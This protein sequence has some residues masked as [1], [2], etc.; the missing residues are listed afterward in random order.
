MHTLKTLWRLAA[1][2]LCITVPQV[3]AKS[4]VKMPYKSITVQKEDGKAVF[5]N[6]TLYG[7]PGRPNLPVYTVTFLLPAQ[8]DLKKISVV[9][10]NT[11]EI[12]LDG[13]YEVD[14]AP[15]PTAAGKQA[16][17]AG[18]NIVNGKDID[19]YQRNAFYPASYIGNISPGKMRQYKLVNV[20]VNPVLYNPVTKKLKMITGGELTIYDSPEPTSKSM[21]PATGGIQPFSKKIQSLAVNFSDAAASYGLPNLPQRM[22]PA[23]APLTGEVYA[24]ITTSSIASQSNQLQNFIN[25]KTTRGFDVQLFDET[26]WGGGSGDAAAENI[27]TWLQ[28]NYFTRNIT[29]V[30]LIGNPHPETGD[31]PMKMA[32]PRS[33]YDSHR[34]C[35]TDFYFAELTGDWDADGDLLVGEFIDDF[36]AGDPDVFAEVSVG[37]IPF[38][39]NIGDLDHILAKIITYENEGSATFQWRAN[40]LIPSE[41]LDNNTPGYHFAEAINNDILYP[42]GWGKFRIYEKNY[43]VNPELTPCSEATTFLT[44]KNG[45]YGAVNWSTHGWERGASDIMSSLAALNLN[46]Q[47]PSIVFQGSCLNAYPEDDQNLSYSL[48]KNGAIAALGA[49]RVSWYY[50]GET[51][52][53]NSSSDFGFSYNFA[54]NIV[55][56]GMFVG[57]ALMDLRARV[58]VGIWMNFLV[59]NVY[60]D[61]AVG[62]YTSPDNFFLVSEIPAQKIFA[63][64]SFKAI[65][66]N[67]HVFNSQ[68]TDDQMTWTVSGNINLNVVISS[69]NVAEITTGSQSWSGKEQITFTATT[70]DGEQK[71]IVA[72]FEIAGSQMIYLSDM[73]WV[74]AT[75]SWGTI[76]K[77]LSIDGNTIT[78][79][80]VVYDKGIGTHA[81]SE[82]VYQL[83]RAYDLFVCTFGIDDEAYGSADFQVYGDDDLL[84]TSRVLHHGESG[85]CELW[86]KDYN[87]LRLVVGDGGDGIGSDHADW[88]DAKLVSGI[89]SP[90]QTINVSV[91]PHVIEGCTEPAWDPVKIYNTDSICSHN[92]HI[93]RAK[94]WTQG[95]EPGTTG[96]WGVWEVLGECSQQQTFY[97]GRVHPSGAVRV[98]YNDS[99][100]VSMFPDSG[101]MVSNLSIDGQ[102]V[103]HWDGY[104]TFR[105]VTTDHTLQATFDREVYY[106][107]GISAEGTSEGGYAIGSGNYYVN[108]PVPIVALPIPGYRFTGWRVVYG[109]CTVA[110]PQDP[111]TTITSSDYCRV[112]ASYEV[113]DSNAD[114]T[115][116][117]QGLD[118]GAVPVNTTA[119]GTLTLTNS[120]S[121]DALVTSIESSAPLFT[122]SQELPLEIPAGTS[123]TVTVYF[124]PVQEGEVN[125]TL[126]ITNNPPSAPQQIISLALSGEG[127]G[128]FDWNLTITP[129]IFATEAV[130]SFQAD[131]AYVNTDA[132]FNLYRIYRSGQ[133]RTFVESFTR[134]IEAGANSFTRPVWDYLPSG[135]YTLEMNNSSGTTL[136]AQYSIEKLNNPIDFQMSASPAQTSSQVTISF[137]NPSPYL[138]GNTAEILFENGSESFTVTTE[139]IAGTNSVVQS[140][141]SHYYPLGEYTVTLMINA[142]EVGTTSFTKVAKDY[143]LEASVSS[144]DFGAVSVGGSKTV[145]VLLTNTG[146]SAALVSA[147]NASDPVFSAT[148]A[149]PLS[150]QPGTSAV[151]GVKFAPVTAGEI[152]GTLTII[153]AP[154]AQV[155]TI[156]INLSGTGVSQSSSFEVI[157][158]PDASVIGNSI[159]PSFT[160]KNTGETSISLSDIVLEYYTFDPS[161]IADNLRADIYYCSI[162][163]ASGSISRLSQ[164]YGSDTQ[165][166]D[167]QTSF[168]F[169]SG[170]LAPNA[171]MQLQAGIHTADWQYN[172]NESDDWSY[173]VQSGNKAPFVVIRDRTTNAILYGTVPSGM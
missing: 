71:T 7:E 40:M 126:T 133:P 72:D 96:E 61:P 14:A 6:Q 102:Y 105:N 138:V 27:R 101:Y 140:V 65:D 42:Q 64:E 116:S 147:M 52:V 21:K 73:D 151:I 47:Y 155:Q 58:P 128:P 167:L 79:G 148:P 103:S 49:T 143:T 84:F 44:W 121:M 19:V 18:R 55:K 165:K 32:W 12:E 54:Q 162:G 111:V 8:A 125:G 164:V 70:P 46:D 132:V 43:G 117:P 127:A 2:V 15:P 157:M 67:S 168:T 82:I 35:P 76:Q 4:S 136:L 33:E 113:D 107:L 75:C 152:S 134:T 95:Q 66:L 83:N 31:V 78:I 80:G 154:D 11:R 62:V 20:T 93:W 130:I 119:S 173:P 156:I 144:I 92:G 149:V 25:S 68:F 141:S 97:Y 36:S 171:S 90:V 122:V 22:G 37:R 16:W 153:N 129:T 69:A 74:S 3:S 135:Y 100:V 106:Y 59:F 98:E 110:D 30:L 51:N 81:Q 41:P 109:N 57:D 104:Y 85:K 137:N 34:E 26:A 50:P 99:L 86:I 150:I 89:T 166:A 108:R 159:A 112:V 172:F 45:A 1:L 139:I 60:G 77:D 163:S 38:Y 114:L 118:F 158:I 120:G 5:K 115:V 160:I 161:V 88:A 48:L 142:Q 53:V 56:H 131:P 94:W 17:P 91:F 10:E 87:Q 29:Y 123:K 9:M 13:E 169:S 39:G 145:E 23:A 24:I 146:N 28:A 63:G 124:H 170:T